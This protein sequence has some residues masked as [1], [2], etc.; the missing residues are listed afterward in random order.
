M[1]KVLVLEACLSLKGSQPYWD[2]VSLSAEHKRSVR[3]LLN[4]GNDIVVY[5]KT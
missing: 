3:P 5:G 2:T 1:D 4:L